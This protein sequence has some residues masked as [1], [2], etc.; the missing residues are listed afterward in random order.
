MAEGTHGICGTVHESVLRERLPTTATIAIVPML[1]IRVSCV[2]ARGQK[3]RA[4]GFRALLVCGLL[5]AEITFAPPVTSQDIETVVASA[6]TSVAVILAKQ[7]DGISSGTGFMAAERLVLTAYHV[8]KNS[9]RIVLKFPQYEA[10]EAR[11]SRTDPQDDVALLSI[12]SIPVRPLPLGDISGAREGQTIIVIGF[13]RIEVLGAQTVTV[14]TGI[15]SAIHSRFVQIQAPISPGNSGGPVLNTRGEVLGIVRGTLRGEQQ[16]INFA[17]PINAAKLLL[18]GSYAR[19]APAPP[20]PNLP[21]PQPTPIPAP[22]LSPGIH[23]GPWGSLPTD[24]SIVPYQGIGRLRLGMQIE[25]AIALL[26]APNLKF[27]GAALMGNSVEQFFWTSFNLNLYLSAIPDWLPTMGPGTVCAV[28]VRNNERY[29][30]V[31][32]LRVGS[33]EADVQNALGA[34]LRTIMRD[35]KYFYFPQ[36]MSVAMVNEPGSP[37]DGIVTEISVYK[38]GCAPAP[39]GF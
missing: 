37:R 30:T 5:A 19:P 6:K 38:P 13:P 25:D 21:A 11:V 9:S 1:G 12:P 2:E 15:V 22:R 36:D 17:V 10:V 7:P 4:R 26:G 35:W 29:L 33:T 14:T 24:Y 31:E 18:A 28:R 34:P 32:G 8:V 20:V 16:G 23:G 27:A 3:E 39:A